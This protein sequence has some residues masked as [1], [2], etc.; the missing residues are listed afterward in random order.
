V[1]TATLP[2]NIFVGIVGTNYKHFT[3]ALK[4]NNTSVSRVKAY[5]I[6]DGLQGDQPSLNETSHLGQLSPVPAVEWQ[7]V[8]N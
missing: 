1:L 8:S 7:R 2:T 3:Y 6:G 5:W 4:A